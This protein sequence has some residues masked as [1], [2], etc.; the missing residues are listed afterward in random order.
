[1]AEARHILSLMGQRTENINDFGPAEFAPGCVWFRYADGSEHIHGPGAI[2]EIRRIET[3]PE[4]HRFGAGGKCV[5]PGCE[6]SVHV[7]PKCPCPTKAIDWKMDKMPAAPPAPPAPPDMERNGHHF[8]EGYYT[9]DH[10]GCTAVRANAETY[11]CPF[12]DVPF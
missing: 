8:R 7:A 2:F 6:C 3:T 10:D 1:M 5:N 11:P 12:I 4:G 9:C